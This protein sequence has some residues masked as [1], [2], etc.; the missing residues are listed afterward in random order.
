MSYA[1]VPKVAAAGQKNV[2][3]YYVMFVATEIETEVFLS[4][5]HLLRCYVYVASSV[6]NHSEAVDIMFCM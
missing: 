4:S 5:L 2:P 1:N 6:S 3:T